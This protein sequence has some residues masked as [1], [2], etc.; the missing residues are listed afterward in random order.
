MDAA[1]RPTAGKNIFID[2]RQR[3][4]RIMPAQNGH[5]VAHAAQRRQRMLQ[6]R[7]SVECDCGFV[8]AHARALA[9]R[10]NKARKLGVNHLLLI[11]VPTGANEQKKD[12][13]RA[14]NLWVPSCP[15]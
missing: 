6:Q 7:A 12:T 13:K 9:A 14:Q 5:V 3:A 11:V 4:I 1:Q 2:R 8:P 15:A 10:K